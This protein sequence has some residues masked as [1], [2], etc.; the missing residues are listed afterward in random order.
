[1]RDIAVDYDDLGA[2]NG[3]YRLN[4][5]NYFGGPE[6][7]MKTINELLGL[8]IQNYV[9]VNFTGFTQIVEA[10]GGIEMDIT[11]AE[12]DQINLNAMSQYSIAQAYGW[13]E[14]NLEST[15]VILEQYGENVHLNGRQ[16]L[17]YARIRKIDSDWERTNP[18]AQGAQRRHGKN[19]G[20]QRDG[21]DAAGH[22]LAAVHR[23]QHDP[24]RHHRHRRAGAQQR[25]GR[26]GNHGAPPHGHLCAGNAQRTIHVLR[27]GLDDHA[28]E[29]Q[30]FIYY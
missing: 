3:T 25:F 21:T 20:H 12:R 22:V 5:A 4:A 10:L 23:N 18:P 14:S 16:A 8:N 2:H 9:L 6:L 27:R 29:L 28:R 13:D 30:N 24:Q 26:C 15:N 17:A 11:E 1:M 7:A 19:A